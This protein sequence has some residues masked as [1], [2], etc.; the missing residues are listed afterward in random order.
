MKINSIEHNNVYDNTPYDNVKLW[1]FTDSTVVY[2]ET[3][4]GVNV[5]MYSRIILDF[6]DKES[7]IKFIESIKLDNMSETKFRDRAILRYYKGNKYQFE[8]LVKMEE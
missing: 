5:E 4:V 2:D 8:E 1:I 6:K 3:V 7:A